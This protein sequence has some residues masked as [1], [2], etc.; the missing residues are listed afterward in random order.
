M[1]E[2]IKGLDIPFQGMEVF[3][4]KEKTLF[5]ED[6]YWQYIIYI[7]VKVEAKTEMALILSVFQR[8]KDQ[9]LRGMPLC[10][11]PSDKTAAGFK[12]PC[13]V[14]LHC[15]LSTQMTRKH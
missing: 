5:H 12:G 14:I 7:R 15:M 1:A 4:Q 10:S 3:R 6:V 11:V 8:T 9:L 2:K 13:G